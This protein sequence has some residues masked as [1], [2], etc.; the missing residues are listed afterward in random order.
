MRPTPHAPKKA[1]S[2]LT[3]PCVA[4]VDLA[5]AFDSAVALALGWCLASAITGVCAQDW[6]ALPADK[7]ANSVLGVNGVTANWLLAFP[8]GQL[9]KGVALYGV[10]A[11]GWAAACGVPPLSETALAS[12]CILD[13]AG[14]L[15]CIALWRRYLLVWMGGMMG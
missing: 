15:V 13:G 14:L 1:T 9:L 2:S 6:V 7:H 12:S 10:F 4:A 11:S 8:L 3:P 5:V